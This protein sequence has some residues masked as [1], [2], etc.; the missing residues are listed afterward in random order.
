MPVLG[1]GSGLGFAA[2]VGMLARG[3]GRMCPGGCVMMGLLK[4]LVP[5]LDAFDRWLAFVDDF[6]YWG[7]GKS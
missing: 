6:I 4:W 5:G 3:R 7:V 2:L 1:F